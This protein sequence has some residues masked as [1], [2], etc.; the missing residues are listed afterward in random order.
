MPRHIPYT[1]TWRGKQNKTVVKQ[2]RLSGKMLLQDSVT[3][4]VSIQKIPWLSGFSEE[5]KQRY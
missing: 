4:Y 3:Q 2:K 5:K 1:V